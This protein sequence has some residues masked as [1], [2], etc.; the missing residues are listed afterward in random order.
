[1]KNERKRKMLL[2]LPLLIIP[3]LTLAF[4]ALGGGKGNA[5]KKQIYE[6]G[7]NLALPSSKL[8][9]D[10]LTDKLSF[11]DK[12]DKDSLKMEEW[13]RNDPY[14]KEKLDG[15]PPVPNELEALTQTTA[16]RYNQKLNVSPYDK[17]ETSADEKVMQ[18]LSL[19]QRELAKNSNPELKD[20]PT[21]ENDGKDPKLSSE[22]DR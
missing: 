8:M 15:S 17:T 14:Y 21:Y 11:Y 6:S 13:M 18:K 22:M 3:F 7:L 16:S 19:L 20:T 10:K 9:E 4:W 5:N 2:V 12:A 1:M